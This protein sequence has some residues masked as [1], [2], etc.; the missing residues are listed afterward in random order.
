MKYI[1]PVLLLA[2]ALISYSSPSG[3]QPF[4][5]ISTFNDSITNI[6]EGKK[7]LYYITG[8]HGHVW[9]IVVPEKDRYTLVSGNTRNNTWR[10]D[11]ISTD[12]SSIDTSVL[13]WGLDTMA[14]N[15]HKMKPVENSSYSPFYVRFVL[16]SS[17]KEIVFDCS[18]TNS[19][20]GVDS[21]TFN[22]KLK[23]LKYFMYWIA[24]PIDIRE[25]LPTP[26]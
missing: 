23:D 8:H 16:F 1:V 22:K 9:S 20:S 7:F 10:I 17:Q 11:T 18:N 24:S 14:L 25:K 2:F 26:F 3:N 21:I 5:V 4:D 19:F 12:M 13:K 6:I 15:Y